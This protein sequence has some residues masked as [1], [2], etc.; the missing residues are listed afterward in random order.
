MVGGLLEGGA[1]PDEQSPHSP[2]GSPL[3][4][5]TFFNHNPIVTLLLEHDADL[6]ILGGTYSNA[7]QCAAKKDIK[8]LSN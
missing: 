5:A 7:L 3:E 6:N 2:L 8:T 1:N 4:A